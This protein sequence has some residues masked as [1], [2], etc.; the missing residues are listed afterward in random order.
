MALTELLQE[1][2]KY[3]A[4]SSASIADQ[5]RIAAPEMVECVW[6]DDYQLTTLLLKSGEKLSLC[7]APDEGAYAIFNERFRTV[8]RAQE[9]DYQPVIETLVSGIAEYMERQ[10]ARA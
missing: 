7:V 4:R 6:V 5:I 1:A 3:G 8:A 2:A 9:D 10:A